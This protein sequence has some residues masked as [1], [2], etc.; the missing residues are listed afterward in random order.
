MASFVIPGMF[1]LDLC[2]TVVV[3]CFLL[4][5]L[6]SVELWC[7]PV[8][9]GCVPLVDLQNF[10]GRQR[11]TATR[12]YTFVLNFFS[13]EVCFELLMLYASLLCGSSV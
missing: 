5:L 13:G 6:V 2:C 3:A 1:C 10:N 4:P 7:G 11:S 8:N 9:L 12:F